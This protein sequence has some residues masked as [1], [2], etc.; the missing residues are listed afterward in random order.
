M[1][2]ACP[3]IINFIWG[4][5]SPLLRKL[6]PLAPGLAVAGI[7]LAVGLYP[8]FRA[9]NII[10]TPDSFW[11]A[12]RWVGATAG[13]LFLLVGIFLLTRSMKMRPWM[14]N[15]VN[16]LFPLLIVTCF[17]LIAGGLA[18]NP[19]TTRTATGFIF[20]P[21][22]YAESDHG[23]LFGQVLIT[24]IAIF[25]IVITMVGWGVFLMRCLRQCRTGK[26]DRS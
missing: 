4:I 21:F 18:M 23:G 24:A 13:A 17:A 5:D 14:T 19:E 6:L 1:A 15:L 22:A 26:E 12:P 9:T 25:L 3:G 16:D 7:F 10:P 8:I 11:T 20:G 2:P